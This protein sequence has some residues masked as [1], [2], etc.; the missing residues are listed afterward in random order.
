[1][2]VLPLSGRDR[3]C[4]YVA[5]SHSLPPFSASLVHLVRPLRSALELGAGDWPLDAAVASLGLLSQPVSFPFHCEPLSF[6]TEGFGWVGGGLGRSF[7][8]DKGVDGAVTVMNRSSNSHVTLRSG[9]ASVLGIEAP[10]LPPR[11]STADRRL[12]RQSPC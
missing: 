1:M 11:R 9:I 10:P 6:L 12:E 3:F 7:R 5:P 8:N 2:Q 4:W